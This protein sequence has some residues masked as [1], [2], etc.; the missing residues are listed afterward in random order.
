[1]HKKGTLEE[2][3]RKK[4]RKVNKAA[5]KAVVGA[6]LEVIKKMRNQKPEVRAAALA[7]LESFGL[8][9]LAA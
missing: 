4:T 1:M 3:A 2:A 5:T 8:L 7:A 6:S 9:G